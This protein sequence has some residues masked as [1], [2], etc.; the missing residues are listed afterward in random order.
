MEPRVTRIKK[1]GA[2]VRVTQVNFDE[3]VNEA[4]RTA[5]SNYPGQFFQDTT[6]DN[7]FV[8]I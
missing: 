5:E 6:L 2:D 3:T 1:L 7:Y 4:R 8:R